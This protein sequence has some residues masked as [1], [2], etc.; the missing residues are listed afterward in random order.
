MISANNISKNY[1]DRTVL[2]DISLTIGNGQKAALVG[3]NGVGKSTLLKILAGLEEPDSGSVIKSKGC[4]LGYLPQELKPVDAETAIN[5]YLRDF[6]DILQIERRIEELAANSGNSQKSQEF[7]DLHEIFIHLDGHRFDYRMK[8]VLAGLGLS[9]LGIDRK[10]G[11]ISG[12]QKTKIGLAGVLLK[13]ADVLLLDEPTNNLDLAAILWLERFLV[14]TKA[15]CLLVCHDRRFVDRIVSRVYEIDWFDHNLIEYTGTYS[16]YLENQAKKAAKA[17][18][19]YELQQVEIVRLEKSA[20]DLKQWTQIGSRQ[21]TRDNDKYIRGFRRD[22]S[23]RS[24]K[25]AKAIEKQIEHLPKIEP[26]KMRK[27]LSIPLEPLPNPGKQTISLKE[28][29]AGYDSGFRI[30][31]I[32]L[33]IG[34][35]ERI[36][37]IGENGSGK[38]TLLKVVTDKI[39]PISGERTAGESLVI[40]NLTQGHENL[41]RDLTVTRFFQDKT[42]LNR[43][44]VIRLLS[45]FNFFP[46]DSDK[47]IGHLSPGE[48]A[49]IIFALFAAQSV[50]VMVLDEPTN[51]L[52]IET[53]TALD[54][55]MDDYVGTV[56]FVSHD[57][58]FL[59]QIRPTHLFELKNGLLKR[60][61]DFL[62]Y[63]LT[64]KVKK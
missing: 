57:R 29:V 63:L 33:E 3:A 19:L 6:T 55:V 5:Q 2:S 36:G 48:R 25:R 64:L 7:Q 14:E 45:R 32:D 21:I 17:Q 43:E 53:L 46:D 38:T 9:D 61:P 10:L 26:P 35:G 49:R 16:D 40:G 24:A 12:G 41:P 62:E 54:E 52:D 22:R 31:P 28:V 60:I 27:P 44:E 20:R 39:E 37:I 8:T 58:Y 34:Y 42:R 47:P 1:G 13:G 59:E 15:A 23:S 51:H 4:C 56:I 11:T 30:G 50:N 18:E